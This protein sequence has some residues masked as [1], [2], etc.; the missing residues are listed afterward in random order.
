MLQSDPG[1]E[2]PEEEEDHWSQEQGYRMNLED[3]SIEKEDRDE[4]LRPALDDEGV[5]AVEEYDSE[6]ED[7]VG[8][9]NLPR[10]EDGER[11][12][13]VE[14]CRHKGHP[15]VEE[16]LSELEGDDNTQKVQRCYER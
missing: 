3:D 1:A 2:L 13:R 10:Q 6:G 8:V 15:C 5:E 7:Q 12:D 11:R 14:S 9:P 16:F 4:V